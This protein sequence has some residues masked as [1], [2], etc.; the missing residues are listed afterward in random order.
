MEV[1]TYV[2]FLS[3]SSCLSH[4][5][6]ILLHAIL[7]E[8]ACESTDAMFVHLENRNIHCAK[9]LFSFSSRWEEGSAEE[10]L[11]QVD[12]YVSAES[13]AQI[14]TV[15]LYI[16]LFH[17]LNEITNKVYLLLFSVWSSS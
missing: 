6:Q 17:T 10:N 3:D 1:K 13:K 15:L 9:A 4:S 14:N 7:W 12:E 11:H 16:L 5:T 8:Q 2:P